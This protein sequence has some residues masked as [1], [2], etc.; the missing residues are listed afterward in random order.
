MIGRCLILLLI[1][2]ESLAQT[3]VGPNYQAMGFTG[4][5]LQGIYSLT[6]NPAGL[7]G[8][9]RLTASVSYQHHFFTADITTQAAL[10]AIPTRLGAFGLA[11]NRYGLKEAYD[12]TKVSFSFAKQFG[13]QF[14]IGLSTNYHQLF[15]PNYLSTFS[16]SVDVGG[17]YH[18]GQGTIIGL[19][20]SNPNNAR[21]GQ[22][23]YGTIP[24]FIRL[25]ASHPL[26]GVLVSV[27]AVYPLEGTLG[28]SFGVEYHIGDIVCLRGGLS[29]N[30]LQQHAGFGVDWQQF[31]LDAAATFHPRLGTS[32]QIGLSYV[33]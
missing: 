19:H 13:T 2:Y 31:T 20:F 5:A 11:A 8:V 18:C 21:Y 32:P 26:A 12:A 17:Q 7:V 23:V 16:L 30:P 4:T 9:E 28:G 14:S 1:S 6:A 15:I 27:D 3:Y 22:D 25:G 24:A 10:L 33:F 29:T